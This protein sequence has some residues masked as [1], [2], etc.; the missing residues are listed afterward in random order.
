MKLELTPEQ[1]EVLRKLIEHEISGIN[2]EIHHTGKA[3]LRDELK[4]HREVL[5]KLLA[6]LNAENG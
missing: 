2:P 5:Q 4:H 6:Q 1:V 3:A